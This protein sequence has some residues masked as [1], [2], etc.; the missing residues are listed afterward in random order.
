MSWDSSVIDGPVTI[1]TYGPEETNAEGLT[2][3]PVTGTIPGYHLNV[4][5]QVFT[6]V[7]TPLRVF[8]NSPERQFAGADTVFLAFADEAQAREHL[9]VWWIEAGAD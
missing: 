9:A 6:D 7:L 3:R 5:P 8:P 1:Y 2:F 4:A